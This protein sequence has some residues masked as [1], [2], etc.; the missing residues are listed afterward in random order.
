VSETN[1]NLVLPDLGAGK[2]WKFLLLFPV[3]CFD[4]L[5][6]FQGVLLRETGTVQAKD[7]GSQWY[8]TSPQFRH[9]FCGGKLMLLHGV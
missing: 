7:R 1:P 6:V 3:F 8:K 9:F 5:N 4:L 2:N